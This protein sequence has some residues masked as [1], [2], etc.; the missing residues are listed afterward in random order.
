[1]SQRFEPWTLIADIGGTSA[2]FA[3]VSA[4]GCSRPEILPT[5]GHP[6]IEAAL[7]GVIPRLGGPA[8][9][10]AMA[11]AVAGPVDGARVKLT[12]ADWVIDRNAIAAHYGLGT[13]EILNDFAALALALPHFGEKDL[14]VLQAGSP[15]PPGVMAVIGP[16]TGLGVAGLMPL[17]GG[18]W[19]PI[20]SEGGHATFAPETAREWQ[21]REILARRHGRI[22]LE[23]V[24][25]GPGLLAVARAL[26][27][28]DEAATPA[29]V[30]ASASAPCRQA[31]EIFLT[32]LGRSAG[33]LALTMGATRVFIGGGILPRMVGRQDLSGLIRA[34]SDKGRISE[35]LKEIPLSVIVAENPALIGLAAH[36]KHLLAL[37]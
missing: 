7:E 15:R 2:R 30:E 24:A 10:K 9:L 3:R 35:R 19:Q 20:A 18:G 16:G 14:A 22:S 29:D 6:T 23:R 36:A 34:F 17:P 8:G 32:V 21:V 5:G 4:A 12:N 33:D 28:G 31:V 37:A 11:I 1:M 26:G 25:S 27:A 13:V